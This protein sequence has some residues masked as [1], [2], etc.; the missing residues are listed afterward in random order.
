MRFVNWEGR[1][2]VTTG[3]R[4]WAVLRGADRSWDDTW[5]EVD[6]AEVGNSGYLVDEVLFERMFAEELAAAGKRPVIDELALA[7]AAE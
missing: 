4:A 7:K 1:P 2:A 3:S 6:S 5:T